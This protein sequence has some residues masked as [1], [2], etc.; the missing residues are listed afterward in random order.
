[1]YTAPMRSM[2]MQIDSA[3]ATDNSRFVEAPFKMLVKTDYTC[4]LTYDLLLDIMVINSKP[5]Q[6]MFI[7][8]TPPPPPP[9]Q[10]GRHFRR[11][12]LETHFLEWK[13]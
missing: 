12:H 10:N 13:C 7:W 8:S 3:N 6:R 5:K 2:Q 9:G 11:R 4:L 1:M